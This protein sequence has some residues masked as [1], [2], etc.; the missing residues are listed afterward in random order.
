[1]VQIPSFS[2]N[3]GAPRGTRTPASSLGGTH[4]IHLSYR[5][6]NPGGVAVPVVYDK[7]PGDICQPA[8]KKRCFC[9]A[10]SHQNNAVIQFHIRCQT[11]SP[12]AVSGAGVGAKVGVG[13]GAGVG[14]GCGVGLGVG[15]GVGVGLAAQIFSGVIFS[16]KSFLPV[17]SPTLV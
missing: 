17:S 7:I 1:M 2:F 16:K 13:C 5:R 9:S 14:V 15:C 3:T 11:E 6:K 12:C 8:W 4:S 10:S